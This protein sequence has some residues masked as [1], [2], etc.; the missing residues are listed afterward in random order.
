MRPRLARRTPWAR[1][2]LQR[3]ARRVYITVTF[4][5]YGRG[6]DL[7]RPKCVAME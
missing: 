7:P 4:N 3:F 6:L 1:A 5:H 2:E